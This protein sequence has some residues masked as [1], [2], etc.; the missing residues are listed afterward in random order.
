MH[1]SIGWIP[2]N[3]IALTHTLTVEGCVSA[4]LDSPIGF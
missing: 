1:F 2:T 3:L 4:L